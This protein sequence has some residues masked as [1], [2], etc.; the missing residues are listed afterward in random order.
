MQN[1]IFLRWHHCTI[2]HIQLIDCQLSNG[3]FLQSD[4]GVEKGH[5]V[6]KDTEEINTPG[7]VLEQLTF[8]IHRL[9]IKKDKNA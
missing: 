9:F 6:R 7:R 3:Q 4:F 8:N 1:T 5:I 2:P